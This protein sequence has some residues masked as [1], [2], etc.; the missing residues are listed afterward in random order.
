LA[1]AAAD[2]ERT[3][4]GAIGDLCTNA[5]VFDEYRGPQVGEDRKSLA[6]RVTMQRFDATI[7]D[8][9]ADAAVARALAAL[10]EDLGAAIRT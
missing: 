8:A 1:V 6:L 3:A 2:V 5:R 4:A 7:T 10:G 9:E